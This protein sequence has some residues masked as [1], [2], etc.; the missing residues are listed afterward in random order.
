MPEIITRKQAKARRLKRYFTGLPC[1]HG[2][3][4]ERHVASGECVGC[5]MAK[6]RRHYLKNREKQNAT[7]K[8]WRTLNRQR[9]SASMRRWRTL[10]HEKERANQR[11]WIALNREKA[12]ASRRRLRAL[13]PEKYRAAQ[14]RWR[15]LNREKYRATRAKW[16]CVNRERLRA[17]SSKYRREHLDKVKQ[18]I[19][20]CYYEGPSN[21]Q[22]DMQ[23][24]RK[25]R[26]QLRKVK[27]MLSKGRRAPSLSPNEGSKQ[28]LSSPS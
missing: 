27:R 9:V 13:N 21:P 11:R 8:R 3:F 1:K 6:R 5:T 10:N 4:I 28:A 7:N 26:A 23:W 19:M 17:R 14:R 16:N 20:K 18:K 12:N 15:T 2:H 22:G 24:V 25:N